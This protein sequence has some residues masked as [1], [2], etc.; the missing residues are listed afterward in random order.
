MSY[1]IKA[2]NYMGDIVG[3]VKPDLSEKVITWD[4]WKAYM[5]EDVERAKRIASL[6]NNTRDEFDNLHYSVYKI[7]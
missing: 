4:I 5:T 2:S 6:K 7:K 3:F 1:V